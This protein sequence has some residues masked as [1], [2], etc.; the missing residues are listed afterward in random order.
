MAMVEAVAAVAWPVPVMVPLMTGVVRVLLVRV[1]VLLMVTILAPSIETTPAETLARVVSVACPSS[2]EPTPR[3]VE[4]EDVSP[5]IGKPVA[6]VKVADDGVPRA[7]PL[8]KIFTPSMETTPA[9]T[10]ASVVSLACPNSIDPSPRAVLV[11]ETR[12]EMGSPEALV[13]VRD[14]GVPPAPPL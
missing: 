2:T 11:E 3:A 7:P 4:V 14:D 8:S 13:K 6:L 9:E 12:P 5:A 10:L 1:S